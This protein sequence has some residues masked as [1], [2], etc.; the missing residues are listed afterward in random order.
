MTS[1]VSR[2]TLVKLWIVAGVLCLKQGVCYGECFRS[3]SGF[4]VFYEKDEQYLA[5]ISKTELL[6]FVA[7]PG[8]SQ[9]VRLSR[10]SQTGFVQEGVKLSIDCLLWLE[11][12]FRGRGSVQ[13]YFVQLNEFDNT[14]SKSV[15]LYFIL[16]Y[17]FDTLASF[18]VQHY[19]LSVG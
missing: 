17:V 18:R 9:V 4:R 15:H 16:L 10:S 11:S 3:S 1:K 5:N 14:A 6:Q 8:E 2:V 19:R 13:W 7:K 12:Q